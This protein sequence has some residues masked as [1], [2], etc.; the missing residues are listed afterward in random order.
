MGFE[1]AAC[2]KH[3]RGLTTNRRP[4]TNGAAYFTGWR[5]NEELGIDAGHYLCELVPD[6]ASE[7]NAA[8]RAVIVMTDA[9]TPIKKRATRPSEQQRN[10]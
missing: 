6:P 8:V 5:F 10:E 9:G 3:T 4:T 7:I 1:A 2:T